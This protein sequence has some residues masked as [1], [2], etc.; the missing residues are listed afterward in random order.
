MT[1][2]KWEQP[3]LT[4]SGGRDV[5]DGWA[6]QLA[7]VAHLADYIAA[8]DFVPGAYRGQP[9]AVAAAILAGREIGIGPMAALQHLHIID[10]RPAMSAQLMRALVFA[11]GHTIRI[12]EATSTRCTIAGARRGAPES[13]VTWTMDDAKR[14]GVA[15][16]Q[17]WA[18]YPRQMLLAR[19]TGELCRA[20]FP[21][22][23]G[24]MAYTRE[25]AAEIDTA[26]APALEAPATRTV[27]R[28]TRQ[29]ARGQGDSTPPAAP[30][31]AETPGRSDV[32]TK[33]PPPP[34]PDLP[35]LPEPPLPVVE[36]PPPAS[37]AADGGAPP[38]DDGELLTA[39]QRAHLMGLFTQLGR[40]EPRALRLRTASGLVRRDLTSMAQLTKTEAT[41][42]IDTLIRITESPDAD[43]ELDWLVTQGLNQLPLQET[44]DA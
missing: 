30:S 15:S 21:D 19:A 23:L 12:V 5:V 2:A 39:P 18:K 44:P 25:E 29:P 27:K 40:M 41:A 9:A 1:V 7:G 26:E 17:T 6:H 31:Q 38:N 42:L 3:T 8:T 16:R 36:E 37:P 14:A 20:I 33:A 13:L 28:A 43:A 35:P 4:P 22:V 34:A 10:G 24:G 11:H 32:Q